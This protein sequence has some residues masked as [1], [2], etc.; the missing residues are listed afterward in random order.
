MPY[1]YNTLLAPARPVALP[2][3][4]YAQ[5]ASALLGSLVDAPSAL[6]SAAHPTFPLGAD[7][8]QGTLPDLDGDARGDGLQ[9]HGLFNTPVELESALCRLLLEQPQRA[10]CVWFPGVAPDAEGLLADLDLDDAEA[11]ECVLALVINPTPHPPGPS[12]PEV[13]PPW[14]EPLGPLPH[15]LELFGPRAPIDD[16]VLYSGLARA[17]EPSWGPLRAATSVPGMQRYDM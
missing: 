2:A 4:A 14:P 15:Y 17:L 16:E 9:H 5:L 12:S 3:A 10:I 8:R 7:L 1:L 11:L 13:E 6:L